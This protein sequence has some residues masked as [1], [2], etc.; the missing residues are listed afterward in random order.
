MPTFYDNNNNNKITKSA[1]YGEK[2][3]PTPEL[4]IL[5]SL[6]MLSNSVCYRA[7]RSERVAVIKTDI[8]THSITL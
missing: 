8:Q 6:Q 4:H 2:R 3:N 5:Y 7:T 1:V